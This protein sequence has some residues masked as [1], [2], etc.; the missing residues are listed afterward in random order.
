MPNFIPGLT[1]NEAFYW[2]AVRPILDRHYPN[3][4]HAAAKI[5]TGSEILG[6]DT[7][8]S[9]DHEW[10]PSLTIFLLPEVFEHSKRAI[11]ETLRQELPVQILGYS[12]HYGPPDL[13]DGGTRIR[14]D[15]DHGP[16][17]HHVYFETLSAFFQSTLGIDPFKDP[18]AADWLT[19]SQQSLLGVTAGKVFYDGLGL[20]ALRQRFTYYPHQVWLYLLAAQWDLIGQVEAFIGRTWSVGDELGSRLLTGHVARLLMQLCFL[21]EKRYAPYSKWFGSAFKRLACSAEMGPLL[22]GAL[23]AD[24][25]TERERCL[26]QVY[27]LAAEMHNA[28]GITPPLE[29]R[30]RTYSGWHALHAGIDEL[31]P[32]DPAN[33]RPH[34]CIFANRFSDAIRSVIRDP[35]VLALKPS[36]GSVEQFLVESSDALQ[37]VDFCRELKNALIKNQDPI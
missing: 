14:V 37:H 19:F 7:P 12:S 9:R 25:Y 5:G 22:E 4:P 8:V 20:E 18:E 6:F 32:D 3:L 23:A 1:L 16:V 35:E 28:L 31:A 2:R 27:T 11:H 30:T 10:G 17:D 15:I 29:T 21:M 36:I 34:Q 13:A 26:A 33:T 24:A